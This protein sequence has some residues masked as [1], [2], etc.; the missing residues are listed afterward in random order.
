MNLAPCL[1]GMSSNPHNPHVLADA[2]QLRCRLKES[3]R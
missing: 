2:V 3:S 1:Y